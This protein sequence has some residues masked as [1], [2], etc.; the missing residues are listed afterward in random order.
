MR[1]RQHASLGFGIYL[2]VVGTAATRASAA[3]G[4]PI[5]IDEFHYDNTGTDTGEFVEV[6][7][8]AGTNMTGW[9]IVLYNGLGGA[10]YNTQALSGTI[11]DLTGPSGGSYGVVVVTYPSNG[12]QNG[13]PDGIAL[14]DNLGSVVQFLSYEG[15]FLATTGPAVGLTST[16]IGVSEAGSEVIGLSLQLTGNIDNDPS[17]SDFTW[18]GPVLNTAGSVNFS[19]IIP[20]AGDYNQNGIV[21]AADYTVWRDTLGSTTDLRANGD[22]AAASAGKVDQADYVIWKSNFGTHTGSGP[23]AGSDAAVPEGETLSMLLAGILT[24]YAFRLTRV[25]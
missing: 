7:G 5:F 10:A 1:K 18:I 16:D 21:D 6:F 8:P 12:I 14:V 9:Q 3:S 20:A 22:N 15:A 24:L 4:P 11:P 25:S 19:H 13:A 2:L 17:Y 23:G